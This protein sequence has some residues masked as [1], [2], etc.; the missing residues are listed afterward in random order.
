MFTFNHWSPIHLLYDV[1]KVFLLIVI[2]KVAITI[3]G[4][5]CDQSFHLDHTP[6]LPECGAQEACEVLDIWLLIS[7]CVTMRS[8]MLLQVLP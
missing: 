7:R 1:I 4:S 6:S 3:G 8:K 2:G 5:S